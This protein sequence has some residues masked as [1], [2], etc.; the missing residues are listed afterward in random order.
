MEVLEEPQLAR[1]RVTADNLLRMTEIGV[2]AHDARVELIEGEVIDMAAMGTKH[3]AVVMRLSRLLERA[4]VDAAQVSVQLPIRLSDYNEPEPDLA[5]LKPRPD[6]YESAIPSG[7]DSLLVIEVS[8]TTLAYDVRIK[9]PLYASH[10]VGEL[11][12]VDVKARTLRCFRQ[13]QPGGW[14]DVVLLQS[15]GTMPLPGLPGLSV[16]LS[17]LF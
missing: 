13:P 15:L 1:H 3:R 16:D 4:V 17:S 9:A 2:V 5:L 6:F 10:G 12:I 14:A 11:W 7:Y 8:D